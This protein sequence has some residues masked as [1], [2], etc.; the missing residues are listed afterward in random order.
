MAG[1]TTFFLWALKTGD[2]SVYSA[3]FKREEKRNCRFKK[4][5]AATYNRA[6]PSTSRGRLL[7]Q[8]KAAAFSQSRAVAR[9]VFS[10]ISFRT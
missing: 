4:T 2:P 7:G 8:E 5:R 6:C 3:A 9:M 1:W 10:P